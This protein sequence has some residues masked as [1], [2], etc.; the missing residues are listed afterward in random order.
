MG[1]IKRVG[2][3]VMVGGVVTLGVGCLS[4]PVSKQEPTT[5]VSFTTTVKQ[6]AVD[7][8]DL[9]LGI[10]NSRSMGDK[11]A[12]LAEAVPDLINS[13]VTPNCVDDNGK[14][15]GER[16]DPAAQEGQEC[17]S[18]KAEF[19]PIVDIHVGIVTSA[20]GGFGSDSCPKDATNPTDAT[21]NSHNND[22]GQLINR[23]GAKETAIANAQ[24][25]NFLS[26]FPAVKRNESKKA[27]EGAT[28]YTA[29]NDFNQAFSGLVGGV[30]EYGCGLEAQLESWYHF[31]IQPD[32]YADVVRE[33]NVAKYQGIDTTILKQ[34]ADFLRPDS[35]VA[36]VL[37]TDED[38]SS[39]DPLALG[40]QGWAFMNATFPASAGVAGAQRDPSRGGSTAPKGTTACDSDPGSEACTSCG[41]KND[42]RVQNDARCKENDGFYG[43][44]EDDMNVRFHKMKKRFGVDP[45]YPIKR[46]VDGLTKSQVPD[47]KSEHDANGNYIGQAKCRNPLFA[48]NLPQTAPD[49]NDPA[50]CNLERGPRSPDLVFF[51]VVGGV[52]QDLLHFDPNDAEKSKI[53]SED[54]VKIIGKDPDNYNLEGIDARMDQSV[55][56]RPGRPA[57]SNTPG[58]NEEGGQLR[59]WDTKGQD[60]QYACTFPLNTPVTCGAAN[61]ETC[62]CDGTKNPP[63]CSAATTQSRAKAYPT[64]REF[65]VVNALKDQGIISSLCP[66]TYKPTDKDVNGAPNPLFGYRPAVKAIVDRLKNALA[67][68]CLPQKLTRDDKGEVACLI[69]ET[70]PNPGDKCETYGLKAPA[71][72]I[73]EKFR[74]KQKEQK[75]DTNLT[76]CQIPQIVTQPGQTCQNN[77]TDAGW[78]YVENTA[79]AKVIGTCSQAIQFSTKGQPP[80][81]ALTDLQCIQQFGGEAT[82]GGK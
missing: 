63:L 68:Q 25:S 43:K 20:M 9:L 70:L 49:E 64:T 65:R 47:R 69:L 31:L 28:P 11:Q 56:A 52:P 30:K 40:G 48:K 33:G 67:N 5:K 79:T 72:E 16:A 29:V 62:D 75:A 39:V 74:E 51:A 44:A 2:K 24:P 60:L 50:L 15:T 42:P 45:Q 27:S 36:V 77:A 80:P 81:G 10:D 76:V 34:R 13:L 71:P 61:R 55:V 82:D 21:L 53:T 38:D 78:C 6:A 57:P 54:W 37:L 17:K 18:G 32:P 59:D 58:N 7:K 35:L 12:I 26:W 3:L 23:S 8:I 66:I 46:Y 19:K 14:P 22:R 73:L 4:R 1:L 41:F